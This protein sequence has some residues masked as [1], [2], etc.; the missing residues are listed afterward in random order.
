MSLSSRGGEEAL[1]CRRT[2]G[3]ARATSAP[4]AETPPST[5]YTSPDI[6]TT[7][8][9]QICVRSSDGDNDDLA[10]ILDDIHRAVLS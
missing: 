4:R 5:W 10:P 9:S 7:R 2:T 3:P 8:N 1:G 6:G